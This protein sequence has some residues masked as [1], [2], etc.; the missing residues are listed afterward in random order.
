MKDRWPRRAPHLVP[1]LLAALAGSQGWMAVATVLIVM[2]LPYG[3]VYLLARCP[4]PPRS[5]STF[6]I[7]CSWEAG[8][9]TGRSP[10]RRRSQ[11][12]TQA[13]VQ[14]HH[15]KA[16]VGRRQDDADSH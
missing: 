1:V 4:N 16:S 8:E 13:S 2:S 10:N 5:V 3:A 6:F 9:A 11:T 7:S 12:S 15:G 14:H